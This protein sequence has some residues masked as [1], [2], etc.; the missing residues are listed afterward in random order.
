MS[1]P[2]EFYPYEPCF[3]VLELMLKL[4]MLVHF[5][6]VVVRARV[7]FRGSFLGFML[8]RKHKRGLRKIPR[9]A[10]RKFPSL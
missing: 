2:L 8:E 9:V 7:R 6:G 4:R 3:T 10:Y 1:F 5:S